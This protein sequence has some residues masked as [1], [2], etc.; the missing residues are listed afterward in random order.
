M[1]ITTPWLLAI[2]LTTT[3]HGQTQLPGQPVTPLTQG[4]SQNGASYQLQQYQGQLEGKLVSVY[5]YEG[6]LGQGSIVSGVPM[7]EAIA[8]V[9]RQHAQKRWLPAEG[10]RG[11]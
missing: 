9:C 8:H 2:F 10:D 5:L 1:R 6:P 11:E 4:Q 3:A 7:D